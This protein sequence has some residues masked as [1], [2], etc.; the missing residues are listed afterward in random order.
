M[1]GFA[2]KIKRNQLKATI[3]A[4]ARAAGCT[5]SPDITLPKLE[6]GKVRM[7]TVAHDNDCPHRKDP[8]SAWGL[9][10]RINAG[11]FDA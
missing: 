7:A 3:L 1:G 10:V 11:E 6:K 4:Q 5:C 9:A 2:R 8:D